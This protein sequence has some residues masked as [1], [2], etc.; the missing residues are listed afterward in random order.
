MRKLSLTDD[1]T[2]IPLNSNCFFL[3]KFLAVFPVVK[4]VCIDKPGKVSVVLLCE[5][6]FQMRTITIALLNSKCSI[7][8]FFLQ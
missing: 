5:S 2:V 7:T 4:S 1:I 3:N 8:D 6:C